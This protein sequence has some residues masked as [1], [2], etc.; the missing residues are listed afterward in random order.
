M[1]CSR[2]ILLVLR[3]SRFAKVVQ[4][5]VVALAVAI[6]YP[7]LVSISNTTLNQTGRA[8]ECITIIMAVYLT[9]SLSTAAL[10]NWYNARAA[11]KER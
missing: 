5:V 1:K 9:L 6:G 4:A 8:V 11:I 10:M 7:D 2:T 3:V